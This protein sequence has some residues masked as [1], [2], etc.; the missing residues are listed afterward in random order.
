MFCDP[1]ESLNATQQSPA[2]P[3]TAD[4]IFQEHFQW[5]R[6]DTLS[7]WAWFNKD[8]FLSAED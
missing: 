4:V 2:L 6:A 1:A 7:F 8:A 3:N 5:R